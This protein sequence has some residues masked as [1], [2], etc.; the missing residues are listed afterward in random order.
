MQS[1]TDLGRRNPACSA[2]YHGTVSAY[3]RG[4]RCP[5]ARDAERIYRKRR[6]HGLAQPRRVPAIG[7][8]RRLQALAALGWRWSDLAER[9]GVT[10]Q[11]VQQHAIRGNRVV[12]VDIARRIDDVFRQ[13]CATAGPSALS[14]RRAEEKGWVPPLAWDD[15]DIDNPD[16]RPR[17]SA[18]AA[19]HSGRVDEAA[20]ELALAGRLPFS[21]LT[22]AEQRIV[23]VEHVPHMTLREFEE[24]L[25][26]SKT[27]FY[28]WR[29]ELAG[30]AVAA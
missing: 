13:L 8:T 10:W 2:I 22:T 20:V 3:E 11:A 17:W 18:T 25:Q 1:G 4:C 23:I 29:A 30:E 5:H 12:H 9:L 28:R 27:T 7:T 6:R 19:D 21:R 26:A 14:R 15:G 24:R 16:A